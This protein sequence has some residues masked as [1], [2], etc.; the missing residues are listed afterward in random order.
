MRIRGIIILLLIS[1]SLSAQQQSARKREVEKQLKTLSAEIENGNR[2]LNENRKSIASILSNLN[3]IL[4]QID[5]RK[6]LIALLEKEIQDLNK[7]IASREIQVKKLNRDL[8]QKKDNY[9]LSVQK[10][11]QQKNNQ[12]QLLFVLS[13][14][15]LAQS[16]RRM[17]YLKEYAAWRK[18][19]A[20]EIVSQQAKLNIEKEALL[21][22]KQ[23]KEELANIKKTEE[24]NL[25][26][27]ENA[28]KTEVANLQKNT[29]EI[30]TE[31]DKKKKQVAA[32]D[33]E[34]SKIIAEEIA[35]ANKAAKADPQTVR[36][37]ETT[38]G[39]AMT[40]EEQVLS[41]S[42]A[43]N[44]GKLPFPLKGSYK[45]V[46]RYGLQQYG[47]SKNLSFNNNGIDIKTTSGNNAKAVFDGVVSSI[48]V[49]SGVL[50]TIVIQHGNYFTAYSNLEQLYVKKGDKVK[51]G[52]DIGKI[53][54][55]R[56]KDNETILH[57][58]LRKDQEKQNPELWLIR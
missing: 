39:Y 50:P 41:S 40:K 18:Q 3:L 56:E 34:I 10:I 20:E 19:Q 23:A 45:I 16:F 6:K 57:F 37:A 54:T 51:T 25:L 48:V 11:Y 8:Q 44:K 1:L 24:D 31:I 58:E 7:E 43:G 9:A 42:F 52:Q 53:Y 47:D 27:E 17:L 21:A 49:A 15:N 32:L 5:A 29:K 55:D 38:G 26:R 12:E 2:L 22:D 13:A 46:S 36:K 35:K 30:Q 28:R 14:N 4:Q 33:R